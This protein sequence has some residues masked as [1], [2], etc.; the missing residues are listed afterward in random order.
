MH[1]IIIFALYTESH[2]AIAHKWL[3]QCDTCNNLHHIIDDDLLSPD[4]TKEV[5]DQMWNHRA[6]WKFIGIQLQIDNS[7]LDVIE[8]DHRKVDDCL[9]EMIN[10][11]LRNSPKSRRTRETIK[12]A[13]QSKQVLNAAGN[14]YACKLYYYE[15]CGKWMMMLS[16][17]CGMVHAVY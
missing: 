10:H 13:L 14:Y 15:V 11:W 6:R 5:L 4:N 3:S 12:V 9:R 7:T 2:V 8:K 16:S 1:I 17:L